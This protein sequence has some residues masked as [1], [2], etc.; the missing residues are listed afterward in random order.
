M[1]LLF[2][3]ASIL[4]I[5]DLNLVYQ[6]LVR[7]AGKWF[8][9]GLDLGLDFDTLDNIK[10]QENQTNLR[11]MIAARLHTGPL[12]YFD[13]CQSLRTPTVNRNDVAEA[14]EKAFTGIASI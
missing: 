6:N 3:V 9:L 1:Y 2:F 13:I 14:I 4:T 5:D 7:A 10:H 12:T 11:E 8:D